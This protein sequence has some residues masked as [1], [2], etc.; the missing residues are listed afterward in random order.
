MKKKRILF[1]IPNFTTAGSGREMFNIIEHL[2]LQKFEPIVSVEKE[3]GNL[4]QEISGKG[5]SILE[6]KHGVYHNANRIVKILSAIKIGIQYRKYKFDI[7][8]S[9]HWS[10][11]YY[12]PIIARVAGAKYIYV[13]KNMNWGKSWWLKSFLSNHIVARNSTMMKK[14]F[15]VWPFRDNTTFITGA[16]D[17]E[18][19][20]V[21]KVSPHYRGLYTSTEQ[22]KIVTCIAQILRI[23]NQLLLVK[24][25]K[26][27][28]NI[29]LLLAGEARDPL[30]A[31]EI[32]K[33]ITENALESKVFLLGNVA[34]TVDLLNETDIFVLPTNNLNGHEEGCP[35]ALLEA[36]ACGVTCIASN[37]AGNIDL[38]SDG[39]N[40]YI[41]ES[42][43]LESL[44]L[45]IKEAVLHPKTMQEKMNSHNLNL[46]SQKF[47]NLYLEIDM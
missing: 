25:I 4:Y 26:E 12:E 24:A 13:K 32:R 15:G 16:V 38:V 40:G 5:Y 10:S 45:K 46:E 23:K 36:M 3:G 6:L 28:P 29:V 30:Y 42:D 2:D 34:N 43:N 11:N 33:F 17:L 18:K 19:F 44:I 9:F 31:D 39:L 21:Q 35:V 41:F 20:K 22:T 8:Q 47:Q 7:W 1:S 27:I 37:I 14:Y